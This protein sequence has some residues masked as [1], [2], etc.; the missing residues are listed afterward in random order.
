MDAIWAVGLLIVLAIAAFFA[1]IEAMA[2]DYF[3][4]KLK[5]NEEAKSSKGLGCGLVSIL[6]VIN[7]IILVA[8]IMAFS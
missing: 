1:V 8:V 2:L 3:S 4:K 6:W 5:S 7:T